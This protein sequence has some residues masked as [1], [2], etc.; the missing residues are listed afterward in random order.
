MEPKTEHHGA[1]LCGAV[2]VLAKTKNNSIGVCHCTTCRKWGGGPLFAVE[3]EGDV[4]FEGA[5]YISTFD[6]SELG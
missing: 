5:E 4:D 3:C 2:R 1:C 6:S